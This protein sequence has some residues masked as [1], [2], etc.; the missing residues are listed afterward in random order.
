MNEKTLDDLIRK[1]MDERTPDLETLASLRIAAKHG[2][3]KV[4]IAED[5][6]LCALEAERDAAK[7]DAEK[8]KAHAEQLRLVLAKLIALDEAQA[9]IDKDRKTVEQEAK[10]ILS[11]PKEPAKPVNPIDWANQDIFAGSIQDWARN[12]GKW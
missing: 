9:N 12:Y 6:R 11:K 8:H 3:L 1:G 10:A 2:A 7:K 4:S 5:P